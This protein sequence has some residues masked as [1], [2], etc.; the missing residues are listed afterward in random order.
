MWYDGYFI[1]DVSGATSAKKLNKYKNS[2]V[3]QNEFFRLFDT[4]MQR[5]KIT[6]LPDTVNERVVLQSLIVYGNVTFFER[7]GNILALPS[8]PS[9]AGYNIN[10]DPVSAWVFSRNGLLNKEIG[11]YVNGGMNTPLIADGVSPIKPAN[12]GVMI[13]ENKTRYPFMQTILYYSGAI[14]D[15]LRTIDVARKWIKTPFIAVAEQSLIPSVEKMLNDVTNNKDYMLV[16]TGIQDISKFNILPI[17]QSSE[18]IQHATELVD[19]YTQQFRSHCGMKANSNI[20][21][22]GENL[23]TDEIHANDS[24]TD[25]ISNT[26]TDYLNEQFDFCNQMLGT[27]IRA[28][29]NQDLQTQTDQGSGEKEGSGKNGADNN[30]TE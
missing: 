6:G 24:Y 2:I 1:I 3:F 22:K 7:D 26:L 13:W 19:W 30:F 18:S 4:A 11:L 28:E 10:G 12:K 8:A 15:T 9:G 20:D 5:Y 21:K 29:V 25:S 14:A 27:N 16:S 23:L 17:E